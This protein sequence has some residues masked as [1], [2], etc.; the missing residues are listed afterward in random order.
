MPGKASWSDLWPVVF[1]CCQGLLV[2][3][4]VCGMSN[5]THPY[6]FPWQP[7]KVSPTPLKYD[8]FK[9]WNGLG[10]A[11]FVCH[12][13]T[14]FAILASIPI[15]PSPPGELFREIVFL[16]FVAFA[17]LSVLAIEKADSISRIQAEK[18]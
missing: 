17:V 8:W 9:F 10:F 5:N 3:G 4:M 2:C 16:F 7:P 14:A 12:F 11:G 1:C 18:Q 6:R 15:L 13:L